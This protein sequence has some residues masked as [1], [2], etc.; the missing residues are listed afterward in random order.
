MMMQNTCF[1][2]DTVRLLNQLINM[3]PTYSSYIFCFKCL[4]QNQV[5]SIPF[6]A[7][8]GG[9]MFESCPHL[10]IRELLKIVTTAG[11]HGS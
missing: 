3:N 8:K 7:C 9:D 2:A 11:M 5:D 10:V 1:L 4:F 6:K